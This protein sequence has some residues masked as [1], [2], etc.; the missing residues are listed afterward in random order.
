MLKNISKEIRKIKSWILRNKVEDV[1]IFG[2]YMRG[3]IN[4]NDIDLCILIKEKYETKSLDLIDS[5]GKLTDEFKSKFHIS[6]LTLSSFV[7]GDTLTKTLLNEGFSIKKNKKLSH[8][9]GYYNKSLFI[10]S[11]NNFSSTKRVKFHY[12][13]KGRYESKGILNELKGKFLGTGTIIIE[14]EYEDRL[15]EIFDKWD[16]KYKIKRVLES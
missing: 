7:N 9:F 3:K 15:K 10:Y 8:I 13:L 16:V 12:L 4:P 11:L 1:I 14:S 5:L 2:S 6:I